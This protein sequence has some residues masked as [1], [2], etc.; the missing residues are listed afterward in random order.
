MSVAAAINILFGVDTKALDKALANVERKFAS[1]SNQIGQ[2]GQIFAGLK[3]FLEPAFDSMVGLARVSD[4]LDVPAEKLAGLRLAAEAANISFEELTG[5]VQKMMANIAKVSSGRGESATTTGKGPVAEAL[6]TLHLSASE[7]VKLAPQDQL[8]K[9]AEA[10]KQVDTA[11]ERVDLARSIFGKGGVPFLT[12]LEQGKSGLEAWQKAAEATGRSFSNFDLEKIKQANNV[13]KM[14]ESAFK[15][16]AEHV[17]VELIDDI[18]NLAKFILALSEVALKFWTNWGNLLSWVI[19]LMI[20]YRTVAWSI[21]TVERAWATA[22]AVKAAIQ[23][24]SWAKMAT[25]IAAVTATVAALAVIWKEIS[26]AMDNIKL[27]IPEIPKGEEAGGG[28]VA[29]L[30]GQRLA[31]AAVQRGSAEAIHIFAQSGAKVM[32]GLSRK[33]VGHLAAIQKNTAN[34]K[35]PRAANFGGR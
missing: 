8:A 3:G 9:I 24:G 35:P 2:F 4:R 25:Q 19:K 5:G 23:A 14:M 28:L 7:L 1:F 26:K 33:Q 29:A 15:G 32:E 6:R 31:P 12:I 27:D 34:L 18:K 11:S 21:V 13:V 10:L 16:L 17:L 22:I 20:L 30:K